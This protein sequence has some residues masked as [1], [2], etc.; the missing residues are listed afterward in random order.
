MD[1]IKTILW[2]MTDPIFMILTNCHPF[3]VWGEIGLL[4]NMV[5]VIIPRYH[6]IHTRRTSH[7]DDKDEPKF[8]NLRSADSRNNIGNDQSDP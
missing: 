2:L 5:L 4:D 6:Q 7:R 1:L 8:L 3:R